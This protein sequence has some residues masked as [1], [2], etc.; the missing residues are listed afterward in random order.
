MASILV[1]MLLAL[2]PYGNTHSNTEP[3]LVRS[4]LVSVKSVKSLS[5]LSR[6]VT[7]WEECISMAMY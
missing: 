6:L 7:A 5:C 3:E 1:S 4:L 2:M